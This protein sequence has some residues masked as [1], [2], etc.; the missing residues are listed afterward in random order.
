[1]TR[2]LGV[3][4]GL[5]GAVALWDDVADALGLPAALTVHDAPTARV[6]VGRSKA[7][8]VYLDAEY[9]RLI[10]ELKPDVAVVE[11]VGGLTGQS[12]SASFQFG[13]GF[14]LVRGIIAALGVPVEFVAPPVWR[15][16]LLVK[17]GKDGSRLRACQL[18]PNHAG[19]FARV[20][21]DGRAESSLIA[22]CYRGV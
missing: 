14:G 18:Y 21:D 7:R 10:R 20:K 22:R 1:M 15:A 5:G 16:R 6:Q 8:A 12:A 11:Q 17:P 4:P 19:L 9:A 2:V 3:D 13:A